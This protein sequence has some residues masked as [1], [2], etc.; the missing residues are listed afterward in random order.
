M[1]AELCLE[2]SIFEVQ[3]WSS[4]LKQLA[5]FHMVGAIMC[6]KRNELQHDL[7]ITG[8]WATIIM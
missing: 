8:H 1:A 4:I 3:L 5:A 7:P 6:W 2:Y